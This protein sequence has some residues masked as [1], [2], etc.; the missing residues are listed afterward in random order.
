MRGTDSQIWVLKT[1]SEGK[2]YELICHN[3]HTRTH[4]HDHRTHSHHSSSLSLAVYPN[5]SCVQLLGTYKSLF[6]VIT[7]HY[8]TP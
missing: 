7:S 5:P 4:H 3:T 1:G 8:P 6:A 2:P